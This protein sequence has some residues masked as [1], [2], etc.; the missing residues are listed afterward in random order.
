MKLEKIYFDIE[1][2]FKDKPLKYYLFLVVLVGLS[3]VV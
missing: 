1:T 2:K 3:W